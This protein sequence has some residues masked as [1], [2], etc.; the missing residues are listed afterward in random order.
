MTVTPRLRSPVDRKSSNSEIKRYACLVGNQNRWGVSQRVAWHIAKR[1]SSFQLSALLNQTVFLEYVA[2][3][4]I[5]PAS[6]MPA[7]AMMDKH[8]REKTACVVS[9]VGVN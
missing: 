2:K 5:V 6:A 4:A 3:S 9:E 1:G 7:S 8:E